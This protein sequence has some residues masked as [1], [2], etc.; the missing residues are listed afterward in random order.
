MFFQ[1]VLLHGEFCPVGEKVR[2]QHGPG[3]A[4]RAL[5]PRL[6]FL[7]GEV[8][9]GDKGLPAAPQAVALGVKEGGGHLEIRGAPAAHFLPGQVGL[10]LGLIGLGPHP[11]QHGLCLPMGKHGGEQAHADEPGD[12]Y[13]QGQQHGEGGPGTATAFRVPHGHPSNR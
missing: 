7:R 2:I 13:H 11:G 10:G 12:A 1:S 3:I 6:I 4:A 9:Q 8:L 5:H